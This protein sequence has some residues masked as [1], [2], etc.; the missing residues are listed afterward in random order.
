[1]DTI[2]VGISW[3]AGDSLT[4]SSEESSSLNANTSLELAVVSFIIITV[5]VEVRF[6]TY[7]IDVT[8]MSNKAF[9]YNSVEGFIGTTRSAGSKNPEVSFLAIALTISKIS[10]LSTI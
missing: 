1:L 6:N 9:T 2:E 3:A 8:D 7:S 10:I 5:G 4:Y